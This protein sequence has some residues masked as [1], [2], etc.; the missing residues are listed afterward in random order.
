ML[1]SYYIPRTHVMSPKQ[2]LMHRNPDGL[3]GVAR[4]THSSHLEDNQPLISY[5]T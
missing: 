1:L 3:A 5:L 4:T 2:V